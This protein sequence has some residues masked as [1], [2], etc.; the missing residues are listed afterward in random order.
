VNRSIDST[1][2]QFR[3]VYSDITG[4]LDNIEETLSEIEHELIPHIERF[5]YVIEA[6]NKSTDG[7]KFNIPHDLMINHVGKPLAS[8]ILNLE[9]YSVKRE[10]IAQRKLHA[11][12][13]KILR[14]QQ[15]PLTRHSTFNDDVASLNEALIQCEIFG[16]GNHVINFNAWDVVETLTCPELLC[17]LGRELDTIGTRV[18][19]LESLS[20]VMGMFLKAKARDLHMDPSLW[21]PKVT[22]EF[23][24]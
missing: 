18:D 5:A 13:L 21:D 15:F 4:R 24:H 17:A 3:D 1:A 20:F 7:S 16:K 6:S 10:L 12:L 19:K 9:H 2:K 11:R 23:P 8:A 22:P 14:K